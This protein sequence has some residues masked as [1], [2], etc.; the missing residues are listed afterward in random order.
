[1]VTDT[2]TPQSVADVIVRKME[3]AGETT[4][5]LTK[6]V[7]IP[8]ATLQRRLLNGGGLQV[9]ELA[10]IAAA[11]GTTTIAILTEAQANQTRSRAAGA[12]GDL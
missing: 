1:M 9:A 10:A 7:G 6:K 11:L 4:L 8:R 3:D 5:G 12:E 2:I